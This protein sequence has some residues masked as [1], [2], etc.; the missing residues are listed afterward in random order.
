MTKI[1]KTDAAEI[2]ANHAKME[3]E[4]DEYAGH[5]I[6]AANRQRVLGGALHPI[7]GHRITGAKRIGGTKPATVRTTDQAFLYRCPR[8]YSA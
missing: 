4:V 5:F 3:N 7:L 2:A 8:A 1:S 6:R